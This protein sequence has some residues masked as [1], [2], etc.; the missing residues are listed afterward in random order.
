MR[1][2][3]AINGGEKAVNIDRRHYVW[4]PITERTREAVLRQLEE[5]ISI[6]D[7]SGIIEKL[8]DKFAQYH[9]KKH[10]LLTN[11]GTSALHS[12]YV[13]ADLRGGDEVIC[14][15]YTFYA[16]VTPLFFTGAIPVLAD[17]KSDGNIDPQDIERK[18][19]EKTRAIVVTHMWGLPCDMDAIIKI[20]QQH[21]LLLFEDASHAYGATFRS[22]R[23]GTFGDVSA[24]SLQAQ[25]T[26]IG[27]N[28]RQL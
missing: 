14:P 19:T 26:L 24:F 4:P 28:G 21:N 20:A 25:K 16:T 10:A 1:S 12:M 7:R 17:S 13:G 3:L 15:A 2:K 23:T 22:R 11:S 27:G 8:E 9:G 18:I 6:Y 5:S